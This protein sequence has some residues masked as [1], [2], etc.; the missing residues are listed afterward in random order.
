MATIPTGIS[1]QFKVRYCSAN[2]VGQSRNVSQENNRCLATRMARRANRLPHGWN[3]RPGVPPPANRYP[4]QT[5]PAGAAKSRRPGNK[6]YSNPPTTPAIPAFAMFS[7]APMSF[8]P[9]HYAIPSPLLCHSEAQPRNLKC[10]PLNP[11]QTRRPS[12]PPTKNPV[13]PVYPCLNP[14]FIPLTNPLFPL[15]IPGT[16]VGWKQ[17][18]NAPINRKNA[19]GRGY[20]ASGPVPA[21][22]TAAPSCAAAASRDGIS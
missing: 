13:N 9:H 21:P 8:Q 12:H 17:C 3:L 16:G 6:P 1:S 2:L 18:L 15:I 4:S 19:A 14:P 5:P 20:T 22:P 10:P 7:P 11:S